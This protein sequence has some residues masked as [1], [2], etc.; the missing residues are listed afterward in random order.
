MRYRRYA[1][2]VYL[3]IALLFA[4]WLHADSSAQLTITGIGL[5]SNGSMI[6]R[7]TADYSEITFTGSPIR[8]C[9]EM[10]EDH[11][12]KW[13]LPISELQGILRERYKTP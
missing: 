10:P 7:F 5:L 3:V 6:A 1:V 2:L 12:R 11:S 4:A 8:V 13:C 9:V